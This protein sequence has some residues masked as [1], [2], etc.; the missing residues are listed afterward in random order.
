MKLEEAKEKLLF[1]KS[2]LNELIKRN[3]EI[4]DSGIDDETASA[5]DTV[6]DEL[7]RLQKENE[8]Y[9]KQLDLDYVNKNFVRKDKIREK[10]EEI[11][12][13]DLEL[14][15]TDS[16]GDIVTKCEQIAVLNSLHDLLKEE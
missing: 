1:M 16:E 14:R 11:K 7:D 2:Q 15:E 13:E 10:I 4:D 8:E 5:I 12:E 6:L 9:S 3:A